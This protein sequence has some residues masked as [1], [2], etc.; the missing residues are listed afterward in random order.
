MRLSCRS[1]MFAAA[2]ALL[3]GAVAAPACAGN[4]WDEIRGSVYGDRKIEDGRS[5]VLAVE[6]RLTALGY[7]FEAA[8][9]GA[10]GLAK[11][12]SGLWDL[13]LV[14]LMLPLVDGERLIRQ[15]RADGATV[16]IIILTAMGYDEDLLRAAMRNGAAGYISKVMPLDQ[17]LMEVHRVLRFAR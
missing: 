2:T 9:D 13:L 11:A 8:F 1:I 3:A 17:V 5:L 16:P 6:D 10:S 12:R 4:A 7:E 14:D 15:L